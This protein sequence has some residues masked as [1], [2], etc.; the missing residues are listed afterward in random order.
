MIL[1]RS[2]PFK[3]PAVGVM[4]EA[5]GQASR[6]STVEERIVWEWGEIGVIG[7]IGVNVWFKLLIVMGF[8]A[9]RP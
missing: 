8:F 6:G 3:I 2:L 7:V 9:W 5:T 4:R 1:R